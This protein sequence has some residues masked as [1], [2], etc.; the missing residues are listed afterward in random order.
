MTDQELADKVVALG[1]GER[2]RLRKEMT[3]WYPTHLYPD[4]PMTA[5]EFVQDWRAAGALMEKAPQLS[6]TVSLGGWSAWRHNY[7]DRG[8]AGP[9]ESL[10]RAIIGAC[11]TAL[12]DQ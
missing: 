1:V 3:Y 9:Y 7:S 12:G 6:Y 10:P 4:Q 11:V 8:V 5:S 2:H